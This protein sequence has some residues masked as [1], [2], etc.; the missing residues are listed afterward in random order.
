M[1]LHIPLTIVLTKGFLFDFDLFRLFLTAI[2]R[3]RINAIENKQDTFCIRISVV[4]H[5]AEFLFLK[6]P[7]LRGTSNPNF[8]DNI[9][10]RTVLLLCAVYI[11]L[12]F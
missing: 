7:L 2:S 11:E 8:V 1:Y 10:K 3:E 4:L 9:R 5:D 12:A 6:I